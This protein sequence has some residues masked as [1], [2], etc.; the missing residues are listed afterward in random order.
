[1]NAKQAGRE[2][3]ILHGSLLQGREPGTIHSEL[4]ASDIFT[5]AFRK[6]AHT[7]LMR[8]I[9]K[10]MVDNGHGHKKCAKLV[11]AMARIGR[12]EDT[13][14]FSDVVFNSLV[15]QAGLLKAF[16]SALGGVGG[17][18]FTVPASLAA[19]AGAAGGGAYYLSE[20][21][22]KEDSE[23][24]KRKQMQVDYYNSLADELESRFS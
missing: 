15:K 12:N 5:E 17:K 7:P 4:G 8:V 3:G 22:I 14:M 21:E 24:N 11:D 13:R 1:M 6:E 16:L 9:H 10:G 2:L 19:A 23:D 20:K 18:V